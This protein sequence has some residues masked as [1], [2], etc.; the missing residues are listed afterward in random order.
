MR[1]CVV[2]I[3]VALLLQAAVAQQRYDSGPYKGFLKEESEL[4]WLGLT[5]PFKVPAVAGTVVDPLQAPI[6]GVAFEI[7]DGS[8]RVVSA[9]TNQKGEFEIL[10]LPK[11][12][13]PFKVTM[14]GFHSVVGTIIVSRHAPRKNRI[15]IQLPVGT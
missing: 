3:A 12:R 5:Q 6:P 2:V 15:R 4:F 9:V 14:N 10:H 11:G 8:G 13:Y 1:S 7:R